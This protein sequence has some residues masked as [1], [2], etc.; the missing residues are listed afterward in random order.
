MGPSL[1]LFGDP[2]EAF[3]IGSPAGRYRAV[4]RW[5]RHNSALPLVAMELWAVLFARVL[6]ES[7]EIAGSRDELA[8]AVG[9]TPDDV[10]RLMSELES[11][12]VV[13]RR[14]ER[15][16]GMRGP[17]RVVYYLSPTIRPAPGN[18]PGGW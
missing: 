7:G 2:F 13:H 1:R 11:L 6:D 18:A 12:G 9:T 16:R 8:E 3:G 14:R 5:L 4:V 17:G 10:S 15:V